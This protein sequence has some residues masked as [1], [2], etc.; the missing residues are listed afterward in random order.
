MREGDCAVAINR[1]S[2]RHIGNVTVCLFVHIASLCSTMIQIGLGPWGRVDEFKRARD[3]SQMDDSI[4]RSGDEDERSVAPSVVDLFDEFPIPGVVSIFSGGSPSTPHRDR[5]GLRGSRKARWGRTPR[6][7]RGRGV[8]DEYARSLIED[9]ESIAPL[10]PGSAEKGY[11]HC[12]C[13]SF[14]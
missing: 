10:R 13:S 2:L 11:R 1:P 9:A 12:R 8:T 14:R 4:R 6:R 5:S 7:P 3:A